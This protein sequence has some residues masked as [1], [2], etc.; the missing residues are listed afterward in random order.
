[1][2]LQTNTTIKIGETIIRNFTKLI[3]NQKIHNHHTFSLEIR[4][5]LLVDEFKSVMPTSQN[6]SGE[7]VSIEIKPIPNLL[8]I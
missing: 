2:A 1:M 8:M 7:K 5:D 6:L 3:V 4:T